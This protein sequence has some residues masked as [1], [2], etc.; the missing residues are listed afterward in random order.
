MRIP[1]TVRND[2]GTAGEF[3]VAI[4][5]TGPVEFPEDRTG[6]V[7][8]ENGS[9]STLYFFLRVGDTPGEIAIEVSVEGNGESSRATAGLP[10]RPGLPRSVR[11]QSGSLEQKTRRF[12]I[13]DPDWAR[14]DTFRRTLRVG[15]LPLIQFSGKLRHLL[16]YPYGCLEQTVT[17]VLLCYINDTIKLVSGNTISN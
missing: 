8:L 3:R 15:S 6:A 14:P 11:E 9:E 2:T 13:D 16:R 17:E 4:D 5:A 7:R 1:V 12:E 10:I